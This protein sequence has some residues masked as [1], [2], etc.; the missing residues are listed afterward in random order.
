MKQPTK[1]QIE[2][3]CKA[4]RSGNY[5]QT[6]GE[7]QSTEGFCCLGVACKVF[8]PV[9]KLRLSSDGFLKGGLP[10]YQQA[11]PKWLRNV[12]HLFYERMGRHLSSLNDDEKLTFDEI[13]DCL[14]AVFIHEVMG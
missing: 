13:A 14:E 11:S 12:S 6:T 1:K 8:I 7:L 2:K 10:S 3:W 9:D 4:L 5:K